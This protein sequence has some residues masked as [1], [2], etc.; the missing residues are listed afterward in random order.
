MK[1]PNETVALVS[2]NTYKKPSRKDTNI[3]DESVLDSALK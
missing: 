2:K 3:L 1:L